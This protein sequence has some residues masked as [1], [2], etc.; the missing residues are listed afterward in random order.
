MTDAD[1]VLFVVLDTVR[2]DHLT[3]YGYD[4]ETTPT[5][6]SLAAEATVYEQA[7]SPAP[8]TLP[9]HAS[10]FTGLYP[11]QHGASQE[12]PYLDESIGTLAEALQSAG[13]DTACY[14]SNAW[15]TPY[16]RLTA[17]FD[18]QDNFFEVMP[19]EFLSGTLADLWQKVN[20]NDT[21]RSVAN[22]LVEV[23]NDIHEYFAGAEGADSKTPEV[24]DN[25][26]DFTDDAD[27][28]F[29]FVNLMDAHLPVYPPEEYAQ[30]F[31]PGVDATEVCQNSKEYNSGARDISESEFEDIRGLYDA[32]IRHMDAELDRLFSHLKETDQWEDTLVVVCA[33]HGELHGEHGLY[34]HEFGIYDPLVNVPLVVKT[35]GEEGRRDDTQ[36]EMQDLYH[37]VLDF[38]GVSAGRGEPLDSTRS[39]LS[40]DY[41][42]FADGEYAF[43][44]YHRPVV[45]LKQL[46]TKAEEAG[47]TLDEES[48]YYSR[49]RAARRVDGKYIRNERITDEAYRIDTDPEERDDRIDDPDEVVEEIEATLREFET[50]VGETWDDDYDP[51]ADVLGEMDGTAKDRLQDL[52]YLE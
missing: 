32:E 48:R 27:E 34:G 22:K 52:G 13:Y 44:E 36:V 46:E 2:K 41:R 19:G 39:L 10:M 31:A 29:T 7:V 23:G 42:D 21:L 38:T 49:M 18:E 3:P 30:Q 45:E 8:W 43:V 14:S 17:G 26:I 40:A 37:T 51:D 9:V 16:T 12:Q 50:R 1:N 35:P 25:A 11:S 33:D 6:E 20:D 4:R 24:I 15:I 28:W 47:I 5:L